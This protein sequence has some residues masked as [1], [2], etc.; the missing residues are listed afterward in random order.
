MSMAAIYWDMCNYTACERVFKQSAEFC[1]EHPVWKLNLAH[2][3]F[4]QDNHFRE[5]IR[6]E[7]PECASLT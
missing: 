6:Q 1:L 5:A 3:Y 7:R 2:T 4:M